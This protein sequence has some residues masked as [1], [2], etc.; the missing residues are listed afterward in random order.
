MT[1]AELA[2]LLALAASMSF[3]PGPNTTL[4]TALAA[5]HG[6]R[7][8]MPFVLA[9]P[10]GWGLLLVACGLGLGALL[11]AAPLARG[12]VKWLGLAYMGWLALK[13]WRTRR[14][15]E[16]DGGLQVGFGQGVL[17]QFVNIKA[18]LLA[19]LVTA[20]WITV[21]PPLAER[22]AWVLPVMMAFALG[23]NL[24]YAWVGST[25]RGWLAQGSRL[26]VFNRFLA[27]VL[28]VTALWM[29]RL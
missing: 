7:G 24:L 3:T 19:L 12:A 14:M 17:L 22:L 28:M 4:S 20:G 9:V 1:A 5:N 15:A 6:L 10:V 29:A 26:V 16:R 25:L 13:L 27:L 11:E 8:A 18:W 2:A 21:R 23:S